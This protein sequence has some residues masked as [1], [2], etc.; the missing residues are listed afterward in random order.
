MERPG[1]PA[2]ALPVGVA[3]PDVHRP[4]ALDEREEGEAR[5]A[6]AHGQRT[7]PRG[8]RRDDL[9]EAPVPEMRGDPPRDLESRIR[10]P[11]LEEERVLGG[12]RRHPPGPRDRVVAARLGDDRGRRDAVR[13]ARIA[14]IASGP[15]TGRRRTRSLGP[16]TA[17]RSPSSTRSAQ[18]SC[19]SRRERD[20]PGVGP[21]LAG[22]LVGPAEQPLELALVERDAFD[23]ALD[24]VGDLGVIGGS[25]RCRLGTSE[26]GVGREVAEAAGSP[27]HQAYGKSSRT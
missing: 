20:L 2:E 10:R 25:G 5:L 23:L 7:I 1:E 27:C 15:R 18:P 17:I 8:D 6:R 14:A 13:V 16:S 21:D 24:L 4:A 22:H 9:P 3:Q 19:R 26:E 12:G 11:R